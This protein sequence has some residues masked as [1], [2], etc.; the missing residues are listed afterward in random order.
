QVR[1]ALPALL[2]KWHVGAFR[3]ENIADIPKASL[4]RF[5]IGLYQSFRSNMD[6]GWTRYVFD[7]LSIP[8]TT[9]HNKDFK[10]TKKKKINLRAKFDV[11]VFADENANI[12]KTGRRSPS[13]RYASYYSGSIPPEYEGGIG[14]EGVEALKSF[15]EQG[16]ILVTLNSACGLAFNEFQVPAGNA[17]ERVDR[18]KFSCPGSILRVKVDN[19]SPIGYGMPREAAIMFYES[20]ALSTRIP[21]V[22]WDRKVVARFPEND[23]LLSGWL[24]G[25]KVI[26]RKAAVVDLQYKKGHIILIGFPC[27]HRAQSHGTYKFL[28]NALLYPEVK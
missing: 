1:K 6:E 5:R 2:D 17:L 25:E 24:F 3:L 23:I 8:Y 13:S 4:K 26:A 7:D 18:S 27:Q 28:L 16:G 12:I 10:G 19:K 21:S 22:G 14:Q 15:V 9:L 11:I 20:M